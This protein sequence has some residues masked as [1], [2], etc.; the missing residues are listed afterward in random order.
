MHAAY[1][2]RIDEIKLCDDILALSKILRHQS[3]FN[4]CRVYQWCWLKNTPA[5]IWCKH[6][7][8]SGTKC[9]H[10]INYKSNHNLVCGYDILSILMC[11]SDHKNTTLLCQFFFFLG[12][13][14]CSL[15]ACFRAPLPRI[16]CLSSN[17]SLM[18]TPCMKN[19]TAVLYVFFSGKELQNTKT[20]KPTPW[21]RTCTHIK[22]PWWKESHLTNNLDRCYD[23]RSFQKKTSSNSTMTLW[24]C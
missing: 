22:H 14:C 15:A 12:D 16:L 3:Q 2:R 5:L 18:T 8:P 10:G 24:C 4:R 13:L 1:M 19:P 23:F 21:Q 11:H 17:R 7:V 9:C 20:A 6:L